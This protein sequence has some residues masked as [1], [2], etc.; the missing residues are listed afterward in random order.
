ME[1]LA[2]PDETRMAT[3]E[4]FVWVCVCS[5]FSDWQYWWMVIEDFHWRF[6]TWKLKAKPEFIE[7]Q[8]FYKKRKTF[9]I[10]IRKEDMS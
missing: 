10:S 1:K 9:D 8:K 5:D 6:F 2:L 4:N 7:E 3:A